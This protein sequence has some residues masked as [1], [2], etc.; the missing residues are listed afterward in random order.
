MKM[1][2]S[3]N[4]DRS[5]QTG[6]QTPRIIA[7]DAKSRVRWPYVVAASALALF[8]FQACAKDGTSSGTGDNPSPSA[9]TTAATP[10]AAMHAP[11]PN[12]SAAPGTINGFGVPLATNKCPSAA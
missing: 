8:S 9:A 5:C 10:P 12:G 6:P 2:E 11:D 4:D 7:M 3:H 1:I